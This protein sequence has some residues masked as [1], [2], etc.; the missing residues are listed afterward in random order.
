ML[1]EVIW[2]LTKINENTEITS[3]NV[4]SWVK[5]MEEPR[6]Q[7]TIMNSHTE[8]K[9]FD[10]LKIVKNNYKESTRR[11]TQT[12]MPTKHTCRYCGSS[13]PSRQCLSCGKKCTECNKIGHFRAMCKSGRA[14]TMN[15]MEQEAAQDSAEENTIN[16][17]NIKSV[18][19]NKNCSVITVNVKTST[20]RNN[21]IVPYKVD[22]GSYGNIMPLYIYKKLFPEV[23]SEQLAATKM[24]V[25]HYKCITKQQ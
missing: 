11:S 13:H 16:L 10:E 19:F 3:E 6:A 5:S 17:V 21:V 8:A 9:E 24:R 14:R 23:T 7:S 20:G 15:E 22:T 4:L 12:K 18:H 25:Y 2:K 1:G